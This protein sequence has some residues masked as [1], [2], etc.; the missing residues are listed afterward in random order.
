MK[1]AAEAN[2]PTSPIAAAVEPRR[3]AAIDRALES[4]REY[5]RH[6]EARLIECGMDIDVAYPSPDCRTHDRREYI[7]AE[8]RRNAVWSLV[9]SV[10]GGS[11]RFSDPNPVVLDAEKISLYFDLVYRD[12]AAQFDAYVAKLEGKVGNAEEAAID[13][14][15]L[16]NGSV[17]T[18]RVAGEVQQWK[19]KMIL[20]VSCL[21]TLFNQFPTR[22]IA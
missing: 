6:V 2:K 8:R 13:N 4:A 19:T 16:W 15:P 5:V 11:R 12:A 7:A 1:N 17:L 18:V 10:N 3:E 22:R 14:A 20:N 21:G 9:R